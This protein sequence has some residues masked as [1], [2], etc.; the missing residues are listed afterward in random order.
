[1]SESLRKTYKEKLRPTLAQEQMLDEVLWR[2][3]TLYNTALEQRITAWGR[4]HISVSRF[5]Q[6]AELKAIRAEFSEYAAIHSHILQDVLARLDKTYQAYF[7]RIQRGEKAGFPRYQGHDRWHSFAFK[8][9]GN[10]ATLDN[11]FL[12]LSKI[13]RIAVRWSRPIEGAP[14]TVTVS[15]EA[16]GWYVCLSCADV[17]TQPLPETGQETGIDL[18]IEAFATLSDGT[19]IFSPGWYRQAERALRTAQRRVTRR[20]RGSHRRRKAVVLLAKAHQTARRQRLDF[21]YK[22]A[23]QLVHTNDVIYHEDLQTA[24]MLRN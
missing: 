9:F 1:M 2:C 7:R 3:R 24:N 21:H 22:V 14:K 6:E 12:V 11:G 4:C 13:G 20:R 23:L 16:D 17:P 18:G 8:E 15:R 5:K 19:R 10:G